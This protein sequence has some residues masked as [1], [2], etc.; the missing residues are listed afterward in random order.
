MIYLLQFTHKSIVIGYT[1]M[2]LWVYAYETL[3][4]LYEYYEY[5]FLTKEPKTDSN[6]LLLPV[7]RCALKVYDR[8][9]F[10]LYV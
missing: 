6:K 7:D 2:L 4:R 10:F 9:I 5:T 1:Y 8:E 3:K